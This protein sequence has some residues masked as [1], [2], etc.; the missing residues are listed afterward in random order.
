MSLE[1]NIVMLGSQIKYRDAAIRVLV[2]LH[3]C[4]NNPNKVKN[5]EGYFQL[6]T[7][8][9]TKE[10]LFSIWEIYNGLLNLSVTNIIS[11]KIAKDGVTYLV[12]INEKVEEKV[13][14]NTY[15]T[16]KRYIEDL[17]F[18]KTANTK[19]FSNINIDEKNALMFLNSALIADTNLDDNRAPILKFKYMIAVFNKGELDTARFDADR[20]K[21]MVSHSFKTLTSFMKSID[22]QYINR[23]M[24]DTK[25]CV[26]KFEITPVKKVE[27]PLYKT[28]SAETLAMYKKEITNSISADRPFIKLSDLALYPPELPSWYVEARKLINL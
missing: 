22:K 8:D 20:G 24:I 21:L 17:I 10:K 23:D 3:D 11:I 15:D 27:I 4:Y 1:T 14:E 6:N 16:L 18:G 12:K 13:V 25:N 19:S 26:L 2:Y 7:Y 28:N 9:C 5:S